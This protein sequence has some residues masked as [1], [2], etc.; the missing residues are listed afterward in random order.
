[1][2]SL[3]YLIGEILHFVYLEEKPGNQHSYN[4]CITVEFQWI[5]ICDID[6]YSYTQR[7]KSF[8]EL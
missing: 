2:N 3:W 1:M 6:L 4:K 7:E 8:A 5:M